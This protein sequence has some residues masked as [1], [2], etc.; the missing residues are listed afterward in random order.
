MIR[1][2]KW[3]DWYLSPTV[4][5]FAFKRA[6]HLGIPFSFFFLFAPFL[7]LVPVAPDTKLNIWAGIGVTGIVGGIV[8]AVWAPGWAKPEWQRRLEDRYNHDEIAEFLKVWRQMDRKEWGRLIETEEGLRQ[9]V[10]MAE[11][12]YLSA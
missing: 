9:L 6:V 12:Q 5:P 8:L 4:P 2:G 3:K 7:A 10:E 11:G 1:F